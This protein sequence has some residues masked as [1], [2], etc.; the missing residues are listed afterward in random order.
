MLPILM[1]MVVSRYSSEQMAKTLSSS[2]M[3]KPRAFGKSGAIALVIGSSVYVPQISIAMGDVK[4]LQD[5][6]ISTSISLMSGATSSGN[7][8]T[9]IVSSVSVLMI[10]IMMVFLNCSAV[11][12]IT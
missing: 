4:L 10:S 9:S 7:I 1:P 8:T 3:T 5:Q 12:I 6:R 11:Q 2:L